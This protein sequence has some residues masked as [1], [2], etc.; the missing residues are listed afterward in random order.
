MS[1]IIMSDREMFDKI[2]NR[3]YAPLCQF[4]V[5]YLEKPSDAEDIV[6]TVF[7]KL[8]DQQEIFSNEDHARAVLYKATYNACL[9]HRRGRIRAL[10]RE[11]Y[12]VGVEGAVTDDFLVNFLRAELIA[13]IH[14]EIDKLPPAY[15]KVLQLSFNSG[16][17]NQEIAAEL[18]LSLQSVKNYKYRGLEI[19]KK[20]VSRDVFVLLAMVGLNF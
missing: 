15:A 17:S 4:A 10:G 20:R 5:K 8:W 16:L 12:Y 13:F 18:G 3:F 9:N 19:L 14:R 2:F 11:E 6:S 7:M 1:E